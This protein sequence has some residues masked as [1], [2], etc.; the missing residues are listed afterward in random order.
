MPPSSNHAETISLERLRGMRKHLRE[1]LAHPGWSVYADF[2]G[3][4]QDD[5]IRTLVMKPLLDANGAFTQEYQKGKYAAFD[6][7]LNQ[8]AAWLEDLDQRI[9]DAEAAEVAEQKRKQ[10]EPAN[11][12]RREQQSSNTDGF[13]GNADSDTERLVPRRSP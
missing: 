9:R 3:Q 7:C 4:V 10:T 8:P 1:L 11:A 12:T 6:D 2:V 13:A 5:L